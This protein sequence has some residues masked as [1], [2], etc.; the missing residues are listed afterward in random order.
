MSSSFQGH[1]RKA[2]GLLSA[3]GKPLPFLD[4]EIAAFLSI[5]KVAGKENVCFIR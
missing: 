4:L 5:G 3:T 2:N 1:G